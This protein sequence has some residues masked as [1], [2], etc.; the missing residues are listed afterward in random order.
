MAERITGNEFT[1][2]QLNSLMKM[3]ENAAPGALNDAIAFDSENEDFFSALETF[4]SSPEL[5]V[6]SSAEEPFGLTG[7]IQG[8]VNELDRR[9]MTHPLRQPRYRHSHGVNGIQTAEGTSINFS[10]FLS[11]GEVNIAVVHTVASEGIYPYIASERF[12]LSER[13]LFIKQLYEQHSPTAGNWEDII[14]GFNPRRDE[15][16][17]EAAIEL[18]YF[19]GLV[20]PFLEPADVPSRPAEE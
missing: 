10:R 15:Y 17:P 1:A 13:G 4:R 20:S 12:I 3:R 16:H 11:H 6:P 14:V 2:G 5:A 18:S 7:S 9:I 19:R 8:I